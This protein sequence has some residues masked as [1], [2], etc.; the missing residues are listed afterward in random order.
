[1][2]TP[3]EGKKFSSVKTLIMILD[4]TLGDALREINRKDL[5]ALLEDPVF[6][7]EDNIEPSIHMDKHDATGK[8][9]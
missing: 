7:F 6:H 9:S 4:S 2:I 5:V 8:F 3:L 1:M